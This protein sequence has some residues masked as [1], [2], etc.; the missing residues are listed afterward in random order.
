MRGCVAS[1]VAS[2][3]G[4]MRARGLAIFLLGLGMLGSGLPGCSDGSDGRYSIASRRA[5][6]VPDTFAFWDNPANWR[7]SFGPAYADVNTS[8]TQFLPCL[9]GPIALCY[10]SGPEPIPC[11]PTAD[12]RFADC[13]CF[14]IPYGPYFVLLTAILNQQVYQ[15]TVAAC[16]ADG[17]GC[18]TPNSAP[19]CAVINDNELI[20]GADLISTFSF[21][22][23]PDQGIGLTNCSP[24]PY[25][26]CMTAPCYRDGDELGE[27][28]CRCPTWTG[29]YQVGQTGAQCVLPG[30]LVWS[31]AFDPT[32]TSTAPPVS[33]C[34]PDAPGGVGCPLLSSSTTLPP[35]TNCAEVCFEYASCR[36]GFVEVGYT[37]DATLCTAGCNDQDLVEQA[38]SGLSGCDVSAIIELETRAQ[39]SCCAS[40]LCGC[41]PNAI[42]NREIGE[43]NALQA[44][45]G[46]QSQCAINGTLCG[47]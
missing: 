3:G 15:E 20:P 4:A 21:A 25:A 44:A 14:E 17:S 40:Q 31:A 46:I 26:G 43:L 23:V 39:C 41:T 33:G 19:V 5:A 1:R 13:T 24:Y 35:G 2:G 22:C 9:G 32:S 36:S 29:P 12:G 47:F 28:T 10:Y 38:C 7:T 37:C 18:Q 30:G 8:P 16:G 45:R 34:V 42:T 11:V 6:F 27:V